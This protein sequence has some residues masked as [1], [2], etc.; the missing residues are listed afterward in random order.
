[1]VNDLD[2]EGINFP[3]SKKDYCN[4]EQ[5][6]NICIN[7]FCYENGLTYPVHISDHEFKDCIDILM[8]PDEN[9]PHYVYI[10]D[11]NRFMCNKTKIKNK[12]HLFRYCLQY[13]SNERVLQEHKETCLKING[14]QTVKLRRGSI[15][16][17]NVFFSI[18][19]FC[20][21]HSRITG[22]QGKWNSISLTPHY[23]FHPL[24]RHSDISRAIT[25]ESSPLHIAS[26]RTRSGNL[27]FPSVS[28]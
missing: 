5:K 14:K 3:L 24:H 12:K 4:I 19:I 8:I 23:H 22:L 20:H 13:F 28:R 18:W 6:N 21:D 7:G 27:W 11:C 15:K 25:A 10:K 9:K 26:R 16:F 2:Y 1:M 17:K